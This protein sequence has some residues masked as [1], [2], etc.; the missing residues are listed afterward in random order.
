MQTVKQAKRINE[1]FLFFIHWTE[2]YLTKSHFL[3]T[4]L[5]SNVHYV[6]QII[7]ALGDK[8]D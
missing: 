7:I 5:L 3:H 1:I 4:V 2:F 8:I 6:Y